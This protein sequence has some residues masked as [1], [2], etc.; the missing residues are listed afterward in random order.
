MFV[1]GYPSAGTT[2]RSAFILAL[3]SLAFFAPAL[4]GAAQGFY[5][6]ALRQSN[7]PQI[8]PPAD[9]QSGDMPAPP[10]RQVNIHFGPDTASPTLSDYSLTVL[11]DILL[12]AGIDQVAITS[13]A[14][15]AIDQM[16]AMYDNL[17]T[18]GV[19]MQRRL[20]GRNGNAVIDAYV[21]AKHT[22]HT[23]HDVRAAMLAKILEIGAPH[24]S[25]HCGDFRT[26][27]VL[28][29]DPHSV[30]VEKWALLV[31][32]AQAERG[33]Q[34]S[35]V[36]APPLDPALHIEIPQ[37]VRRRGRLASRG[38]AAPPN[39]DTPCYLVRV[40]R[41][42][43]TFLSESDYHLLIQAREQQRRRQHHSRRQ[44]RRHH[45]HARP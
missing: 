45:R 41:S 31:Q 25:R 37:P 35:R 8:L 33:D 23:G 27:Q 21:S 2:A 42:C 7:I 43:A 1:S 40:D 19:E 30:P 36:I 18:C 26:L 9:P 17:E 22:G 44:S 39:R 6:F 5:S 24:I 11:K 28:D 29:I 10:I 13:T 4:P 32:A 15:T 34:V 20:Y 14:R 16:R 3:F 38:A 12:K